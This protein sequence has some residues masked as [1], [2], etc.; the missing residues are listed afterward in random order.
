MTRETTSKNNKPSYV[1]GPV[2]VY[3]RRLK[4]EYVGMAS[5]FAVIAFLLLRDL[6]TWQQI[7]A[8][9]FG[10][11]FLFMGLKK[12]TRDHLSA[13]FL[14][15]S[16]AAVA[17]GPL[18]Q[19]HW[20]VPF[21]LFGAV[22]CS[23]EGYVEKL[24]IYIYA[25]PAIFGLWA[26]VDRS[27]LLGWIFALAYLAH[28]WRERP[29][30]RRR[31][32]IMMALSTLAAALVSVLRLG[33]GAAV[34]WSWPAE[35]LSLDPHSQVLLLVLGVP[36]SLC[37]LVYWRRLA[38]AHRITGSLFTLLAPLDLRALAAY[39]MVATV[40]LSATAL[41]LSVDS[42]RLRPYFKHAEWHFFWYVLALAIWAGFFQ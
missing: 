30:L 2:E 13:S 38:P 34:R 23:M 1:A 11:Y 36:A 41:R 15:F 10:T 33:L 17:A 28:P 14:L 20:A 32:G 9:T 22:V 19:T 7:L 27:W 42:D 26:W 5:V 4:M 18:A 29:G 16:A 37:L 12:K 21:L 25:L 6:A 35:R 24:Q 8:A 3:G 40:I 31:L 39:A